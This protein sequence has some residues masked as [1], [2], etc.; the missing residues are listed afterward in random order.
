MAPVLRGLVL[1]TQALALASNGALL[2]FA[3]ST[4]GLRLQLG[5]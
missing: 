5:D 3:D 4:G 1:H 2:G